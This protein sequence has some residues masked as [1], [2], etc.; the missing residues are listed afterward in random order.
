MKFQGGVWRLF[1]RSRF[2]CGLV[3]VVW[4]FI[5]FFISHSLSSVSGIKGNSLNPWSMNGESNLRGWKR[6]FSAKFAVL[7]LIPYSISAIMERLEWSEWR[8]LHSQKARSRFFLDEIHQSS[9]LLN[10]W[11]TSVTDDGNFVAM[12]SSTV[13]ADEAFHHWYGLSVGMNFIN[14]LL[15]T[16]F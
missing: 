5:H 8:L 7:D 4:I 15:F 3:V 16:P 9:N 1:S 2:I 12:S 14:F 11:L 13:D 10:G 6:T